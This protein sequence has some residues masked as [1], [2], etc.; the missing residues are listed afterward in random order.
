[1]DPPGLVYRDTPLCPVYSPDCL[2]ARSMPRRMLS[3]GGRHILHGVGIAGYACSCIRLRRPSPTPETGA[4]SPASRRDDDS[5]RVRRRAWSVSHL[6][7]SDGAASEQHDALSLVLV[8]AVFQ[9]QLRHLHTRERPPNSALTPIR[10]LPRTLGV[11]PMRLNVHRFG[12]SF[13]S[14][15]G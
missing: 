3:K 15:Q 14:R 2:A 9:R 1:M 7:C 12:S 10:L 5:S 11:A 4:T 6:V 13:V 8:L